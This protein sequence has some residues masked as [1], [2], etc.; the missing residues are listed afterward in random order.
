MN[1]RIQFGVFA[2]DEMTFPTKPS[3]GI[4]V[5]KI[6]RF[7]SIIVVGF[8]PAVFEVRDIFHRNIKCKLL[9]EGSL[10]VKNMFKLQWKVVV[11]LTNFRDQVF[12]HKLLAL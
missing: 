4:L 3:V 8:H 11:N 1:R 9:R 5:L 2:F 10:M 7:A 6:T 12:L